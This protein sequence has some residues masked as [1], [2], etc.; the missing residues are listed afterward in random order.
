MMI[1]PVNL[2]FSLAYLLE[3]AENFYLVDAGFRRQEKTILRHIRKH[4]SKP[5]KLI[6]ITHAHVDHY[7]SAAALRRLT[8]AQVAVHAADA[9]FLTRGES[10]LGEVRGRGKVMKEMLK[11]IEPFLNAEAI[12][13]DII[14]ED[15]I[16]LASFNI[17]AT[18]IH[19]PG[20]TPGSC[21]LMLDDGNTFAGD[22]VSSETGPHLQKYFLMD[23]SL[24]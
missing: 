12:T 20:H 18:V 21:C 4:G 7:G 8:G 22:M 5:L 24:T 15:G 17:C 11:V 23:E 13:P 16:N 2:G 9:P 19:S 3:D 1:H 6:F 10:P 14:L